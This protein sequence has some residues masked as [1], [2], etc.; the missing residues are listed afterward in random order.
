MK[1]TA[2]DSDSEMILNSGEKADL[3]AGKLHRSRIT[4]PDEYLWSDG[5]GHAMEI[6][7]LG[8]DF[9][10]EINHSPNEIYIY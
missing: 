4:N 2:K 9:S 10:Y 3:V 8:T 6:L 7:K 1:I 5:I